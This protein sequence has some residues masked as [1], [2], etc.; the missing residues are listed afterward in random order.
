MTATVVVVVGDVVAGTV[1]A[2][3]IGAVDA[4]EDVWPPAAESE[5][6]L[7]QATAIT[8]TTNATS[9]S[10]LKP[11]PHLPEVSKNLHAQTGVC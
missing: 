10:R 6:E 5:S 3:D 11:E 8:A 9:N 1:D 4:V 7:L 2:V